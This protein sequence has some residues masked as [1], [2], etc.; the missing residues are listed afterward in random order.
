MKTKLETFAK[1]SFAPLDALKQTNNRPAVLTTKEVAA[2]TKIEAAAIKAARIYF[3]ENSF[4]EVVVPHITRI[5]GACENIDTLF[6][7]DY[8]G[9]QAYLVQTGQLYLEALIPK[10]GKVFCIG[11]SFR[12]EGDIDDRHLTEF[13]LVEIEFPGNFEQLLAHIENTVHAMIQA[14]AKQEDELRLLNIDSAKLRAIKKPFRRITYAQAIEQ[15][16]T[17]GFDIAWGDDLKSAH[18]KTLADDRPLFI[19]HYPE[20]IKFF[21]MRRNGGNPRLV[22]SCDLILPNSGEAVGA[23]EREH[24]YQLLVEKLE[25]SEMY[26]RLQ[27]KGKSLRD[28]QWYLDIVKENP[29]QHAGCGIG[30]NRVVQ[31]ILGSDDIRASTAFPMN[32]ESLM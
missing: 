25:K 31:F 18:E 12:A 5:T 15:L 9:E 29:I 28:F 22:N 10:L 1:Q 8:F 24:D 30:L 16:Q 26:K 17:K 4:T 21:N 20:A 2:V 32:R 11:P 6:E 14:A 13:A 27:Q 3:E 19:T 7:L 23:A